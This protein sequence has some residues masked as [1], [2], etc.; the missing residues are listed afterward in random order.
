MAGGRAV[1]QFIKANGLDFAYDEAGTGPDIALCL[2]GFPE[3]RFSWRHQL[4]ALAASGWHAIAPD[5]RGYGDTSRPKEQAAYKIDRL[6][7]DVTALFDAFGARRRLLV[8][9]DWGAIVAWHVAIRR[10]R[11]LDGLVIMNVPHPA[12]AAAVIPRSPRQWL[13]SW[14]ILFFLLP[15]LPEAMLGARGAR[16]IGDAFRTMAVDKA[17]FPDDVLAH[18]RANARRPGAL[19]AMLNY[20]RANLRDMAR[21][22]DAPRIEVPTLMIWGEEDTAL[23]LEL[24]EGYGPYVADFTLNRLPRVSHWVQQEAPDAVNARMV[25]WLEARGLKDQV[26]PGALPLDQA[27]A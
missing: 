3:S 7:D 5:L 14:Y 13:R 27:G 10:M 19:T 22:G 25:A 17:A 18:Y 6:V 1:P 16:A 15:W 4:P 9:H 2:H 8:A 20:Y 24:T 26:R 21:A 12:V 23:G 11:P